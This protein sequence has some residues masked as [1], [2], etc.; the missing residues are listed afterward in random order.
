MH[1]YHASYSGSTKMYNLQGIQQIV[2]QPAELHEASSASTCH[3][4]KSIPSLTHCPTSIIPD[5]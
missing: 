2:F 3:T 4:H 1:L 5:T